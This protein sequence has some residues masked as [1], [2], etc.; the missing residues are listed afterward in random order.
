M[1]Y[2]HSTY[3]PAQ[4][5]YLNTDIPN[6]NTEL[7]ILK[8][9]LVLSRIPWRW[10]SR[11]SHLVLT[12]DWHC[13]DWYRSPYWGV[14]PK[15]RQV[16]GSPRAGMAILACALL[17]HPRGF[18]PAWDAQPRMPSPALHPPQSCPT[19]SPSSG[20]PRS[21]LSRSCPL[22]LDCARTGLLLAENSPRSFQQNRTLT[23]K[24]I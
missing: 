24:D 3:H 12:Q 23:Q 11:V 5:T 14:P 18:T 2:Q 4:G 15:Y 20:L 19:P 7:K 1:C 8:Q 13:S 22:L 6:L 21:W 10:Y 16:P 17:A 9:C